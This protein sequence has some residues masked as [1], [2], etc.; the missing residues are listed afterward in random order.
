MPNV[1]C[2]DT[3]VSSN[4]YLLTCVSNVNNRLQ[5]IYMNGFVFRACFYNSCFFSQVIQTAK[6][7]CVSALMVLKFTLETR[8]IEI[9]CF[10][11]VSV[12][13]RTDAFLFMNS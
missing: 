2:S 12:K 3:F 8:Y 5:L 4:L 9:L 11:I 10:G 7:S 6:I 1:P 13:Q